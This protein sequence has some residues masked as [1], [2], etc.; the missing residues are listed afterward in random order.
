MEGTEKST[1][2]PEV[3]K[4]VSCRFPPTRLL[5]AQYSSLVHDRASQPLSA[6]SLEKAL[7]E[8]END[9]T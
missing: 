4:V 5:K 1:S 9:S 3:P 6:R 2:R 8:T 7:A